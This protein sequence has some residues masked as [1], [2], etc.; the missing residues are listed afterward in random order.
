MYRRNCFTLLNRFDQ[1]RQML[2]VPKVLNLENIFNLEIGKCVQSMPRKL[3]EMYGTAKPHLYHFIERW[4]VIKDTSSSGISLE[5]ANGSPK[6]TQ[7]QFEGSKAAT[8]GDRT[9]S[10]LID[11]PMFILRLFRFI[12]MLELGALWVK[13]VSD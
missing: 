6:L 3:I 9:R 13:G 8:L 10:K 2:R 1:S 7:L 11:I 12:S 5:S 4:M